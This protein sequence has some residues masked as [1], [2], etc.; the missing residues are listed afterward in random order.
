MYRGIHVHN[1]T[2]ERSIDTANGDGDLD[3]L[4]VCRQACLVE[5]VVDET[6]S[7]KRH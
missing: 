6:S 4:E 1:A 2:K 3:G 5:A 7:C